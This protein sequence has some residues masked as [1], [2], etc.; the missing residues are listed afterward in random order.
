MNN[1]NY[2]PDSLLES[3]NDLRRLSV[4]KFTYATILCLVIAGTAS[5]CATETSQ[6]IL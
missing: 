2:N 1:Q 6:I 5:H 4:K 3:R